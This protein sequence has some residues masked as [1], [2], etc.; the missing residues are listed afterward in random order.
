[1]KVLY[2]KKQLDFSNELKRDNTL[3]QARNLELKQITSSKVRDNAYIPKKYQ[4]YNLE[5]YKQ[6]VINLG[7]KETWAIKSNY[8]WQNVFQKIKIQQCK[9]LLQKTLFRLDR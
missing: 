5:I 1:M 3:V 7:L 6:D 8:C 2:E 9:R 4:K